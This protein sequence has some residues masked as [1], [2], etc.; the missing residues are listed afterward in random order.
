MWGP[1]PYPADRAAALVTMA[2]RQL[3]I[4]AV[5]SI[6]RAS[7][8]ALH[9]DWASIPGR[10]RSIRASESHGSSRRR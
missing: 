9:I 2:V 3:S 5:S 10:E 7:E 1:C 8:G 6:D 4:S